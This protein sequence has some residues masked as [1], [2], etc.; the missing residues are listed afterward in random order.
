MSLFSFLEWTRME[1]GI[2]RT[3]F[4]LWDSIFFPSSSFLFRIVFQIVYVHHTHQKLGTYCSVN[5]T[6]PSHYLYNKYSKWREK[7][8]FTLSYDKGGEKR[9]HKPIARLPTCQWTN[10]ERE[11]QEMQILIH[12][13]SPITQCQPIQSDSVNKSSK[14]QQSTLNYFTQPIQTTNSPNDVQ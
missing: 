9:V 14:E 12:S 4:T 13:M 5:A 6:K 11:W 7:Q 10:N 8:T 3:I 1:N 2:H